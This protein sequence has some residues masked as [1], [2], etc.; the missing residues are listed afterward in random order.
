MEMEIHEFFFDYHDKLQYIYLC[1]PTDCQSGQRE[2]EWNIIH[3][4]YIVLADS[5]A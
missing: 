4:F 3:Y 1:C 2:N 5:A